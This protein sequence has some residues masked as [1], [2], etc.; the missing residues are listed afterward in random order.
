MNAAQ[1]YASAVIRVLNK[2]VETQQ[3]AIQQ[4]AEI[5]AEVIARDGIIYTFGTGHSHIIAEDVVYRAGGLAP[6][7]AILEP[8]LTG[9]QQV[10]KSEYMERVEGIAEVILN[11]YQISERDGLVVISNSG[12]NAAPIE[13]AEGARRRG[14]KVIAITSLDHSRSTRSRHSSGKKLYEC[15]DVV[16]DNQCPRGDA[17][18]QLEGL[19][20]PVGPGSSISGLFILHMIMVQTAENLLRQ[21][22]DPPV[23]LSGNLDGSDEFNRRFLDRYAGRVKIW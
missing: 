7:D 18:L 11:Y 21:G 14:C 16:I 2:V 17:L 8:S 4:A 23:F 6:I 10:C 15:A 20:Q 12:R 19:Q 3:E 13:M 5:L 1:R 9:H 22:I